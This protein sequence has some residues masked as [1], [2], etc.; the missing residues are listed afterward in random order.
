M[1][2]VLASKRPTFSGGKESAQ[3]R[4]GDTRKDQPPKTVS[5]STTSWTGPNKDPATKLGKVPTSQQTV[6]PKPSDFGIRLWRFFSRA[7]RV[8][9]LGLFRRDLLRDN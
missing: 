3:R 1:S 8:L 6:L 5:P 2:Y 9:R 4:I 7:L